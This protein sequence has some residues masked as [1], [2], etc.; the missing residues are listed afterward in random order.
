[1]TSSVHVLQGRQAVTTA[2]SFILLCCSHCCVDP[3]QAPFADLYYRSIDNETV[4]LLPGH[5]YTYKCSFGYEHTDGSQYK[6]ITCQLNGTWSEPGVAPACVPKLC[7]PPGNTH[8]WLSHW[9][10]SLSMLEI[11]YAFMT[12]IVCFT[13]YANAFFT[14]VYVKQLLW[15]SNL[16]TA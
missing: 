4:F 1:M 6:N 3:G 2:C 5:Y 10:G 8:C 12:S 7:D 11:F 15:T 14:S 13:V 9:L 16:S